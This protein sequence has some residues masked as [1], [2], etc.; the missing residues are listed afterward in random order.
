MAAFAMARPGDEGVADL[1]MQRDQGTLVGDRD[2]RREV[3]RKERQ[4]VGRVRDDDM[5]DEAK[6]VLDQDKDAFHLARPEADFEA[7][8][9][10]AV[11][12]QQR[13]FAIENTLEGA[14][15]IDAFRLAEALGL[16]IPIGKIH[17]VEAPG[18]VDTHPVEHHASISSVGS[19]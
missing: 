10:R 4:P 17:I 1:A 11:L 12:R 19:G 18:V 9:G 3:S 6:G 2:E 14:M 16:V 5:L 8:A 13:V 7:G 15:P